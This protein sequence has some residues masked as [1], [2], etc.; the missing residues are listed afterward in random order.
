MSLHTLVWNCAMMVL[1]APAGNLVETG[2]TAPFVA[3]QSGTS[4]RG[5]LWVD[6][7]IEDWQPTAK[8]RA[9]DQIGWAKSLC[10]A[11]RLGK[12]HNRPIFLFTYSGANIA[13]YRC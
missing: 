9:F 10:D 11:L 13:C 5:R 6:K 7:Q 1:P 3:S 12:Q 8:E 2:A 4:D